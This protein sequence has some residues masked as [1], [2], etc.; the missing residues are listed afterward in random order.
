MLTMVTRM[1]KITLG[2][3][4]VSIG[5]LGLLLPILPG[6][7]FLLA[8]MALLG[9]ESTWIKQLGQRIKEKWKYGRNS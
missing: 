2:W 4:L 5:I 7:P 6:T 1:L 8:G 9:V 3:V